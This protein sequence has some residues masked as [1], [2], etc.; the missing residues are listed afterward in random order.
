MFARAGGCSCKPLKL[1][2]EISGLGFLADWPN[3]NKPSGSFELMIRPV[4]LFDANQIAEIYNY[5]VTETVITF[6]EDLVT[7][8]AYQA[9]IQDVL[10]LG[11]P[12][13]VAESDG[14]I[15]GY[16]YAGKW[17]QRVAYK[18]SVESAVYVSH[19][20]TDQG[21]G[22]S[23]YSALLDELEKLG[24][25]CVL[26]GIALPNP[27]SVQLHERLGFKKVAHHHEVG[28]KFDRWIDV[29]FWQL[30]LPRAKVT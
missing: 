12:W 4:Q 23:L 21:I 29:G 24:I 25:H 19:D 1:A 5:Y 7:G 27:A 30:Q 14:K 16:A 22:S 9:R 11:M 2:Y 17:R 18:Y 3:S 13:L 6:E 28:R 15:T 8:E 10:R 20:R 26:G